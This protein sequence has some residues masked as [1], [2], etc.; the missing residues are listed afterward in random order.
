MRTVAT[1]DRL[2]RI[3]L[4]GMVVVIVAVA[5]LPA[6]ALLVNISYDPATVG[7]SAD[8]SYQTAARAESNFF[9]PEQK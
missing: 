6:V 9:P 3:F 2:R 1:E 8:T 5:A 7:R 4:I